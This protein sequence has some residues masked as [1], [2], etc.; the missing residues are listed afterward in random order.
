M[1]G[2]TPPADLEGLP[3]NTTD[4]YGDDDPVQVALDYVQ[5][6][7]L[8]RLAD[9][10]ERW[11]AIT[12]FADA[13]PATLERVRAL[14]VAQLVQDGLSVEDAGSAVGV[15]RQR[16]NALLT[17]HDQP[18]PRKLAAS[19]AADQP[20]HRL[21]VFLG[22]ASVIADR[23]DARRPSL[24]AR[25]QL[26]KLEASAHAAPAAIIGRVNTEIARWTR[27]RAGDAALG[28]LLAELEQATAQLDDL[29]AFLGVPQQGH[30]WVARSTTRLRL[31]R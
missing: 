13:V 15:N 21:G 7:L 23:L 10:V 3:A 28:G 12:R 27:G 4:L 18:T 31:T 9:P 17:D 6:V 16:A 29:P 1:T 11:N 22:V 14:C 2:T 24:R 5:S 19:P 26:D 30:M 25:D 20:G 8:A